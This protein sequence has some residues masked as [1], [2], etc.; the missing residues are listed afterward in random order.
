MCIFG[1][2]TPSVP[3]PPPAPQ[4]APTAQDASVVLSR[5]NER[6]RR[7]AAASQTILT[8]SQGVTGAA[9]TAAKTLLG[10]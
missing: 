5:D 2:S 10:S 3:T 9:P 8:S 7:A 4:P 6:R 1:G